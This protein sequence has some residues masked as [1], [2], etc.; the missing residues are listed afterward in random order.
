MITWVHAKVN[1]GT[2]TKILLKHGY[3]F[4]YFANR[5][6]PMQMLR[7]SHNRTT[8]TKPKALLKSLV[9]IPMREIT[10]SIVRKITKA[11]KF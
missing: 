2:C 11:V 7:Y 1:M 10:V 4:V 3:M 6:V 9:N 8:P 5:H